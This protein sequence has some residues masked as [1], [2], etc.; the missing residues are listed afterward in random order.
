MASRIDLEDLTALFDDWDILEDEGQNGDISTPDIRSQQPL[1]SSTPASS[2]GYSTGMKSARPRLT[3][4]IETD[5]ESEVSF[6][7]EPIQGSTDLLQCGSKRP[8]SVLDNPMEG[9][10]TMY[11]KQV[12]TE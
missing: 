10:S 3:A 4:I 12:R 6:T 7:L 2:F 5:L 8:S 1:C 9:T 11:S